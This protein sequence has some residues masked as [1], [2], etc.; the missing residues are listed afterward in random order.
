MN[1]AEL[2]PQ[3]KLQYLE[4]TIRSIRKGAPNVIIC[5]YCGVKNSEHRVY[6]CCELF[7]E[8]TGAILDRIEKQEAIDFL[9]NVH[10]QVVN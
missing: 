2:T 6:L 3:Q 1:L 10:D 9:S 7:G 5:P 4:D 8:A